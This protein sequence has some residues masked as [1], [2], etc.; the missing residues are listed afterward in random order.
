MARGYDFLVRVIILFYFCSVVKTSEQQFQACD[1]NSPVHKGIVDIQDPVYCTENIK[2]K[3]SSYNVTYTVY[4]KKRPPKTFKAYLC[5]MGI[6]T[7]TITGS[8]WVGVYDTVYTQK[9][10]EVDSETCWR[11]IET[12]KCGFNNNEMTNVGDRMAFIGEPVGEGA[13]FSTKEYSL[14]NCMTREVTLTLENQKGDISSSFG[15]LKEQI[16]EERAKINHNLLVWKYDKDLKNY[17]SSCR[18]T[19]LLKSKGKSFIVGT[20]GRVVDDEK[21]LEFVY[22]T[23]F[24]SV[25]EIGTIHEILGIPESYIKITK[26][27]PRTLRPPAIHRKVRAARLI[28]PRDASPELAQK[29]ARLAAW[30]GI[31]LKKKASMMLESYMPGHRI[32]II[33]KTGNAEIGGMWPNIY[34]IFTRSESKIRVAGSPS[35]CLVTKGLDYVTVEPCTLYSNNWFLIPGRDFIV[36]LKSL[37]C[38]TLAKEYLIIERCNTSVN[39]DTQGWNFEYYNRTEEAKKSVTLTEEQAMQN[40]SSFPHD[41]LS[42][43]N[44]SLEEGYI[45]AKQE[46]PSSQGHFPACASLDETKA[47]RLF[48][49]QCEFIG[50]KIKS[51]YFNQLMEY[52]EDY[53]LRK[54]G[55]D[56]CLSDKLEGKETFLT[57]KPCNKFSNR[58]FFESITEQLITISP[59][60]PKGNIKCLGGINDQLT[61]VDCLDHPKAK[62]LIYNLTGEVSR[63]N[64]SINSMSK[65]KRLL[66]DLQA[67]KVHKLNLVNKADR[68]NSIYESVIQQLIKNSNKKPKPHSEERLEPNQTE[69]STPFKNTRAEATESSTVGPTSKPSSTV[70]PTIK[71]P[72]LT[73]STF[74]SVTTV[75]TTVKQTT[76]PTGNAIGSTKSPDKPIVKPTI[77][78]EKG[79]IPLN[80]SY[81]FIEQ[82]NSVPSFK[83]Q[84][85]ELFKPTH[86]QYKIEIETEHENILATE[87]RQVYCQLLKLKKNQAIMMAQHDGILA[88]M[89]I[90]MPKCAR[91]QGVGSTLILQQCDAVNIT[92]LAE[93][94]RCGMQPLIYYNNKTYTI[95]LNGWSLHTY[96]T[97]FYT[98]EI[99]TINNKPYRWTIENGTG[100]WKEQKRQIHTENLNLLKAFDEL[101][102]NDYNYALQEHFVHV[103]HELEPLNVLKD[104]IGFMQQENSNTIGNIIQTEKKTAHEITMFSWLKWIK[105]IVIG[106]L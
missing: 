71:T 47:S 57:L 36:D 97:C 37:G 106:I 93:E 75:P 95:G 18:P 27:P 42:M 55:S 64:F 8:F 63:K 49:S 94:S 79:Q 83:H 30:G 50:K 13:W 9:T 38:L 74:V 102:I 20:K 101:L 1:C 103:K 22:S 10:L 59:F 70:K 15:I 7:K 62:W 82:W 90:N 46:W 54:S 19:E 5:E 25:C 89:A 68:L 58:W 2:N 3:V 72:P 31:R 100:Y 17:T 26:L 28:S 43:N 23:N 85:I 88:A 6:K 104:L 99:K 21:E 60:S 29:Y 91:L 32:K 84:V 53:T 96:Q 105:I 34:F 16:D 78:P 67:G 77:E 11:M 48:P 35:L 69:D 92:V 51:V 24:T 86:E 39:L 4:T 45:L 98:T 40:R 81:D 80:Y 65:V 14:I 52:E 41:R 66:E 73:T 87:I 61:L 12:K 33:N 56:F 44:H 76:K